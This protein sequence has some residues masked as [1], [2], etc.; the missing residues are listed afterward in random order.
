MSAET[1]NSI[2]HAAPKWP[3][4]T[5][6]VFSDGRTKIGLINQNLLVRMVL[7][8]AIENMHVNLLFHHSFPNA[9]IALAS[10]KAALED[11][12]KARLPRTAAIL[13]RLRSDV[14]YLANMSVIVSLT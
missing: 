13:N 14:E 10:T 1:G 8:D 3:V 6:M 2:A 7:Q 12:A 5:E 4:E 9:T 11:A